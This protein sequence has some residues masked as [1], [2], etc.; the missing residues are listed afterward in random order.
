M[1]NSIREIDL[2]ALIPNQQLIREQRARFD[3][4]EVEKQRIYQQIRSEMESEKRD[5]ATFVGRFRRLFR[6]R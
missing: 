2:E 5:R 3:R 4:A 6:M 1:A